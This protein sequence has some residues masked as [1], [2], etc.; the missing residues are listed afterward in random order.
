M[1]ASR[2]NVRIENRR[3]VTNVK[4]P[5]KQPVSVPMVA[6]F[7]HNLGYVLDESVAAE[8]RDRFQEMLNCALTQGRCVGSDSGLGP[9][10]VAAIDAVAYEHPDAEADCIAA[11]YDAYLHEHG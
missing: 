6:G 8:P 4:T 11:A 7:Q 5:R 1:C 2:L 10:T 3:I 9:A